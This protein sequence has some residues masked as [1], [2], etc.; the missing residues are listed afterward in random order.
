MG[1]NIKNPET[2]RLAA[3]LAQLTGESMTKAVTVALEERLSRVERTSDIE[4][5]MARVRALID[6]AGYK[7][8]FRAD[9]DPT[10]FLYDEHGL[11]K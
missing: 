11:P 7:G 1:L 4:A 10:A 5:R 9:E 3:R 8:Q 2:Y 6:S